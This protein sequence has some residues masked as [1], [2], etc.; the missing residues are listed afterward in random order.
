MMQQA[1]VALV[2]MTTTAQRVKMSAAT[3]TALLPKSAQRTTTVNV[4]DDLF[5]Y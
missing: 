5:D 3:T 4:I 2:K 1:R